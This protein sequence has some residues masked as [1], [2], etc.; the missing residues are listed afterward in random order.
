MKSPFRAN[1]ENI[2]GNRGYRGGKRASE[3]VLYKVLINTLCSLS[4]KGVF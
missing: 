3:N 4:E 2:R 1:N